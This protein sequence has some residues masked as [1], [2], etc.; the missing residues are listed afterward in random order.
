MSPAVHGRLPD[1]KTKGLPYH[2]MMA[3]FQIKDGIAS[4]EDFLV[5]SDAMKIILRGR[6]IWVRTP[7]M[8]GLAFILGHDR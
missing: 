5:D 3:T 6:S 4:T 8:Q 7:L 2:N 1:L